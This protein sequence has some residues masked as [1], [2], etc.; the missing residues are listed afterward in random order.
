MFIPFLSVKLC[1]IPPVNDG[2]GKRDEDYAENDGDSDNSTVR[3][4]FLRLASRFQLEYKS[5][6]R[7]GYGLVAECKGHGSHRDPGVAQQDVRNG[8]AGMCPGSLACTF[9]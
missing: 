3:D 7:R 1:H 6:V 5:S 8:C 9:A 2:Q 4:N